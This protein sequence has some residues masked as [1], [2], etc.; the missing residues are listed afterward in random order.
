MSPALH[1]VNKQQR[2]TKRWGEG[3][4]KLPL[5]VPFNPDSRP[6]CVCVFFF[7][8]S[9]F[10]AFSR[11]R[12]IV[13]WCVIFPF[14]SHF[15]PPWESRLT[16]PLFSCPLICRSRLSTKV[17]KLLFRCLVAAIIDMM[18]SVKFPGENH[19]TVSA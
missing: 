11:L 6:V 7:L 3:G 17:G 12:N 5:S 2:T 19:E 10:F 4:L 8:G 16:R 9:R 14:F 13:Q 15:S 1:H 18:A